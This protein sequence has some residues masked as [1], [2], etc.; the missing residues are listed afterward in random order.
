MMKRFIRVLSLTAMSSVYLMAGT[1][2][3]SG[4]GF[5]F[6]PTIGA[7]LRTFLPFLP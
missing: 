3:M 7:T 4:D 1:C 6:A 2:T 5:S